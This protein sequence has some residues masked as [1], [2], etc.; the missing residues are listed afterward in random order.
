MSDG[1]LIGHIA[2]LE[3]LSAEWDALAGA[4]SNPI[5]S[6][7]WVLAWWHHVA[8]SGLQPRAVAVRDHGLLI[9]LVPFYARASKLGVVE[10][11]LM[12]ADFG[13][14]T[15]PLA[16]PGRE[17]EVAGEVGR[18]LAGARPR[19]DVLQLGPM[20]LASPWIAAIRSQWPGPMLGP[21]RCQRVEAAPIVTLPGGCFE[22]WLNSLSAKIKRDLRRSERLF[23][24]AGGT[25][26]WSTAESLRADVEAFSRLHGSRWE[27]RGW[28]RLSDLGG[29]LTDWLL[30]LGSAPGERLRMCVLEVDGTP[31]CVDFGL[32]AGDEFA[33]I[34]SGWDERYAKL[35]PAKLTLLRK[36]QDAYG[37]GARRVHLGVGDNP[38]KVR[39]ANGND[40]AARTIFMPPSR[41]LPR[42]YAS[43]LP[44]LARTRT[45]ELAKRALPP[46]SFD[47]LKGLSTRLRR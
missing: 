3:A 40:P 34:N 5:A 2:E 15:E 41:R 37:L 22:D 14:C 6:P 30:E 9:G 29:A 45:R 42:A 1:E 26:R 46:N 13:A 19:V 39:L 28:S 36:V 10:Y 27:D 31:V 16:L 21:V 25:T 47:A 43:V 18:L 33:A 38:N 11:G 35:A 12:A 23:E 32:I 8:E 17:W 20:T 24:E 4:A 7:S 44:E